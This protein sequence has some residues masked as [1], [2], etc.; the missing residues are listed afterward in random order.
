MDA[1]DDLLTEHFRPTTTFS[2]ASDVLRRATADHD[3][4]ARF[5]RSLA[6]DASPRGV[7]RVGTG[8]QRP[9]LDGAVRRH[10]EQARAELDDYLGGRRAYFGVPVDLGDVAPFQRGVLAAAR[11]IPFGED[12]PYA[13]I[14]QRIGS[15]KA[16]RAVGTALGRNPVPLIVP[17]H[18]VLRS[19][20][21]TGGYAFGGDTKTLLL[22]LERT[23]PVLMGCTTTRIVCR[24]GCPHLR[25]ARDDRRVVFASVGDAADVGYRPCRVCTP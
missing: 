3:A 20:G 7:T 15:P 2:L 25:R 16:V 6:I 8:R 22:A 17:C 10:V 9:S 18:R 14:A 23:T 21:S 24:V 12:R 11:A 13:W 1:L 19:D 4:L 5:G